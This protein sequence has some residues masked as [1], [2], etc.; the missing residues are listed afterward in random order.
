MFLG[1]QLIKCVL[2]QSKP[3]CASLKVTQSFDK[4]KIAVGI[5]VS[6]VCALQCDHIF[7]LGMVDLPEGEQHVS[8]SAC[9]GLA[10]RYRHAR[11]HFL[12]N[13]GLNV[14]R[15]DKGCNAEL[16]VSYDATE[17][18]PYQLFHSEPPGHPPST[19]EC[20]IHYP[21]PS[22]ATIKSCANTSTLMHTLLALGVSMVRLT[23]TSGPA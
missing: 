22:C 8:S 11:V 16:A 17:A 6:G 4:Q 14:H 23:N 21:G 9:I 3:D 13:R 1:Q 7:V 18:K 12:H 2:D 19:A 10:D 15:F 20:Q 5:D